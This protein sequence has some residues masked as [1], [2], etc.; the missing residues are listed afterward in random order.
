MIVDVEINQGD[1]LPRAQ[2]Q[3]AVDDGN[4]GI[5]RQE[6]RQ[7]VGAAVPARTMG[8]TSAVVGGQHLGQHRQQI[9]VTPRGQFDD[10]QAGGG[11]RDEDVEH[12]V[13]GGAGVA[14]GCGVVSGGGG[15]GGAGL[16]GGAGDEGLTL[17]GQVEAPLAV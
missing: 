15:G 11:V 9:L 4:R 8:V 10:G 6:R 3:P 7:H 5:G 17:G 14:G 16:G 2:G 13:A 12:P 1:R